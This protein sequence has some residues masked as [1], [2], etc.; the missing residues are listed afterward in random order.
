MDSSGPIEHQQPLRL[1]A[2]FNS[3]IRQ[4]KFYSGLVFLYGGHSR[5]LKK[6]ASQNVMAAHDII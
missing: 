1:V 6:V 3:S 5:H 4:G 2:I